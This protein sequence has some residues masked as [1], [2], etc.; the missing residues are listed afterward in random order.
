MT[1]R[2]TFRMTNQR[3]WR[4]TVTGSTSSGQFNSV[5]PT[6]TRRCWCVLQRRKRLQLVSRLSRCPELSRCPLRCQLW[7][8]SRRQ[9]RRRR[10]QRSLSATRRWR[11]T[12]TARHPRHS[13][14]STPSHWPAT[15]TAPPA[16]CCMN[17]LSRLIVGELSF[18]DC[19]NGYFRLHVFHL[20]NSCLYSYLRHIP[21]MHFFFL[22]HDLLFLP[23]STIESGVS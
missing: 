12:M 7:S 8:V 20:V 23:I 14:P 22:I 3:L 4:F 10:P 17:S 6:C 16:S 1:W 2:W 19:T 18:T 15:D 11:P 13:A 5:C 21:Q 9:R